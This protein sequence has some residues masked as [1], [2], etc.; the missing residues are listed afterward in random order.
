MPPGAQGAM[1]RTE[2]LDYIIVVEG[3]VEL[4]L[5]SGE[6]R[7]VRRGDVVVQR[8]TMHA[9]KNTGEGWSR[10]MCC[11]LSAEAVRLEDGRVLEEDVARLEKRERPDKL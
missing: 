9:W 6:T 1:H 11:L 5:D 8:G 7:K 2:S 10:L 4:R 3:E